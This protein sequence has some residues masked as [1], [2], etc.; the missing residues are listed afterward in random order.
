VAS[1]I[2]AVAVYWLAQWG[3][4]QTGGNS[5]RNIGVLALAVMAGIAIY[6]VFAY[7]LK[8]PELKEIIVALQR[9]QKKVS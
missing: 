5:L 7:L 9:K 2:M 8:A 6:G 3:H 4:W 1:G